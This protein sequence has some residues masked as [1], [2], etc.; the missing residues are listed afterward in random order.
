MEN[1]E[2]TFFIET[3]IIDNQSIIFKYK[4]KETFQQNK[5]MIGFMLNKEKLKIVN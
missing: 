3:E 2:K 4:D 1:E 5:I